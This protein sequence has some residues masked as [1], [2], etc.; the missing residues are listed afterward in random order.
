MNTCR[1][2]D[3]PFR[4]SVTA[5]GAVMH[6]R[7]APEHD[8]GGAYL[9]EVLSVRQHRTEAEWAGDDSN[10]SLGRPHKPVPA[11]EDRFARSE[12]CEADATDEHDG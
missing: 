8:L 1:V 6:C 2:C 3:G 4:I 10:T 12:S 11:H 5:F 7:T 9:N